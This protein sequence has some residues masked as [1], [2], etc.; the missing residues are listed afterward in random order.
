MPTRLR[1]VGPATMSAPIDVCTEDELLWFDSGELQAFPQDIPNPEPTPEELAKIEQVK[2]A[3]G[4]AYF[5]AA[6]SADANTIT[7]R[8]YRHLAGQP[9]V[10]GFA[11][12][13]L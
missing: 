11:T 8:L 5:E 10:V 6:E 2:T 13:V 4:Q 1:P 12:K 9:H 3:F 7:E